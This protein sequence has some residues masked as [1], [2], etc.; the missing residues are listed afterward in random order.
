[1]GIRAVHMCAGSNAPSMIVKSSWSTRHSPT[2]CY[3]EDCRAVCEF[4]T[5]VICHSCCGR[6]VRMVLAVAQIKRYK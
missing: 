1:M 2:I 3:V 5:M 4:E 6:C